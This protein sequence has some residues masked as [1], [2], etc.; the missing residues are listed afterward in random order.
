[1]GKVMSKSAKP[2]FFAK[3]GKTAMFG[4]GH[5]A[6]APDGVTGYD[7]QPGE[8]PG[9]KFAKGGSGHMFGKGHA[10]AAEAGVTSKNSQ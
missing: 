8:G 10:N 9:G 6:P 2:E 3:G 1:M 7:T 4:K 5:A